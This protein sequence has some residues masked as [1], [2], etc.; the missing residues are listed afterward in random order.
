MPA[1]TPFIS[2]KEH[3]NGEFRTKR[4]VLEWYAKG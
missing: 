3:L 2:D 1:N 4:L